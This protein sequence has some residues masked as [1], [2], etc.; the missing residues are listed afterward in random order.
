ML[1][2][3][4]NFNTMTIVEKVTLV[5]GVLL[6]TLSL[7]AV[8]AFLSLST[9]SLVTRRISHYWNVCFWICSFALGGWMTFY[10]GQ[11]RLGGGA[12]FFRNNVLLFWFLTLTVLISAVLRFAGPQRII[13][14]FVLALSLA[15]FH[16][17]V[18]G[19][20]NA[21]WLIRQR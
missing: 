17:A 19:F 21:I 4:V 20:L 3:S 16:V 14:I 11:L 2:Q 15:V 1:S 13:A 5:A 9:I 18:P 7:L 12:M 8:L 10:A 6:V